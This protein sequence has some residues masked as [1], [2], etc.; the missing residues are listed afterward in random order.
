VGL[1]RPYSQI[2]MA[3]GHRTAELRSI[4]LHRLVSGRLDDELVADTRRR[5][6]GWLDDDGPEHP[7]YIRRWLA[8]L[9]RPL[10]EVRRRL[11]EDSQEMRDLRQTT[12]FAGVIP[13]QERL[14]VIARIR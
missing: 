4:E 12:P 8:L 3:A 1:I 6:L 10:D 9:D 11:V 13:D 2:I 14:Q 5:L 7:V